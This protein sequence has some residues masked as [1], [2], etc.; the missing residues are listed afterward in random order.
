[1]K[2]K[3]SDKRKKIFLYALGSGTL[4]TAAYFGLKLL[5][6]KSNE[7]NQEIPSS[8]DNRIQTIR[9]KRKIAPSSND[10][11]P[12][13]NGSKG[14]KVIHLQQA[15]ERILGKAAMAKL[16]K[17]DGNFKKGTES[18]LSMA[19]L[20]PVID[21]VTFNRITNPKMLGT[22]FEPKALAE[23][24]LASS[25]RKDIQGTLSLLKQISNTSEYSAVNAYFIARQLFSVS[26]SIVTF[27]LES[28]SSNSF[29]KEQIKSEFL[30][31]GLRLNEETGK[32]SLSGF[33]AKEDIITL[34]DTYVVDKFN[35]RIHVDAG[36]ILGELIN[37]SSGMAYF[38]DIHGQIHSVPNKDVGRA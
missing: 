21:E 7:D 37:I 30:R 12:L 11:F 3:E 14:K 18:A 32:W 5:K 8:E 2:G 9:P 24:L 31:I 19:K 6:G 29:H 38:K 20:P 36:V 34:R 26:K 22:G 35:N 25:N 13:K 4:G 23:K 28:F 17:I 15:L 33:K 1:M 16:T 10:N 27:L